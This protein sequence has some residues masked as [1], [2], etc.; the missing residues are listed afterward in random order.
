MVCYM[1][2]TDVFVGQTG[3][4]NIDNLKNALNAEL[5]VSELTDELDKLADGLESFLDEIKNTGSYAS[6]YD[7]N[8]VTWEKLCQNCKCNSNSSCS[9]CSCST[10]VVCSNPDQCCADCDV[11]KAAKIF[12]GF[13]PCLYYALKYLYDKCEGD[14]NVFNISDH[15]K[16]LR[17]FLIGMGYNVDKELNEKKT[18]REIFELLKTLFPS[19]N[20]PLQSLYEKSKKYFTSLSSPSHVPSSDSKPKPKT[21]RDIL[22]WLYGLR[23]TSGF[24]DLLNHCK[25]LCKPVENSVQFNDFET[26]LFNSCF[27]S[28]FVLGVIEGSKS[29]EEALKGFP[30]YKSEWQKFLYPEDPYELLDLLFDYVRKIFVALIFL[31]FQCE[32]PSDQAGWQDCYFGQKCSVN[33]TSVSSPSTSGCDCLNSKAYLCTG[34]KGHSGC[35]GSSPSC[36]SQC[37]HHLM[38]FLVDGSSESQSTSKDLK[39]FPTPFQPPKDFPSMGFSPDNLPT[40]GRHGEAL[41]LL[42][43][44]FSTVSFLTTLLKFELHVSRTPPETLGELFAFFLR[45]KNPSVFSSK[46][47]KDFESYVS[48]EP[49]RPDGQNFTNA[50]QSALGKLKGSRNSH[51][52][53]HSKSHPY[54]L[55]SLSECHVVDSAGT[56]VTCGRY[57]YPLTGDVY[58]IF[59]DSPDVYLSWV[60][61]L[62]KDFKT[63]LEEFKGKFSSC[64]SS[65]PC[66]SIVKCPCALPLIYSRGFQ[67]MSPDTLNGGTAKKCS[68][69]IDQLGKVLA[70]GSPLDLLIKQIEKFLWHIRLPFVYAFLYIWILVIS[71]FYY[72]Q[73]YKLDLLHIDSHLHLP[74]SF[75]ILPSTL[76]SDASS[77]LKD[78]SYFTL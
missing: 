12:L 23:F 25:G 28:P 75:K 15:D 5:K 29:D 46:L 40:P 57:L 72:V 10:S 47:K 43:E 18:G 38:R 36:K 44:A 77:K 69:F 71:Y 35:S 3:K 65:G 45:F 41:Y 55:H 32:R 63:L 52:S 33:S 74:R 27:L 42:L 30:P 16:P 59:I 6:S 24:K 78:L 53:S 26:S 2:Y 60:C 17:R 76:F 21:V 58:D 39:I 7:S 51:S 50:F 56:D 54:D 62:P 48:T 9:S 20:G 70:S 14:W 64:C 4:D 1:Y 73:F 66:S 13:I 68:D 11:K 19:S 37:P 61:Y 49:G 31:K 67:F 8:N 22:L 34:S